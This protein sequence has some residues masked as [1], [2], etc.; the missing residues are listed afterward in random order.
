MKIGI[1]LGSIRDGRKAEQVGQWVAAAAAERAGVEAS[2]I[3]LKDFEVPLLTSA[4]VPGAANRQYD[5]AAV[6]AWGQAIDAQDGFVFVTP[7]YNHSIPGAFKNA[8][9]SIGPEWAGKTVGFVAYGADGGVRAVEHWRQ[10]TANFSMV[11]V[12]AQVSLGLFTDFDG[13][14]AFAPID[15][16]SAELTALLDELTAA[17]ERHLAARH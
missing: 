5:N 11:D 9:D 7:E 14:G 17:T 8:F 10:I 15:R 4:T 13:A 16:R 6:T 12:R 2:V 3:D 1:I